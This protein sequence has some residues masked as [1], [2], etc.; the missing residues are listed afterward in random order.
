MKNITEKA[1]TEE[2][3]KLAADFMVGA[4]GKATPVTV[5][6][7]GAKEYLLANGQ[8]VTGLLTASGFAADPG[9]FT[10]QL[11]GMGA[12]AAFAFVFGGVTMAAAHLLAHAWHGA[13]RGQTTKDEERVKKDE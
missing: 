6:N 3:Q 5:G 9:Q 4:S 8:G 13:G 12:I 7:V 11:V 1:F 10:A 2:L